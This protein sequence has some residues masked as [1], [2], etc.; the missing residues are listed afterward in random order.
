MNKNNVEVYDLRAVWKT[1]AY[2]AFW[3]GVAFFAIYPTCN[4]ISSQRSDIYKLYFEVELAIPFI[5]EFL[6]FYMSMYLLF[7]LP[8]FFLNVSELV[9]LGKRIILGTII[10]GVIFLLFPATLG[11]ERIVPNGIYGE[12]FSNIFTLDLPYNMAPSLHIVY[13]ALILWGIYFSSSNKMVHLIAL[14]WILLISLSTLLV[15]QHHIMDIVLAIMVILSVI[16][17]IKEGE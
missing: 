15:H 6:W 10:S 8:P 1:Y 3:V 9:V 16:F 17:I 14:L 7:F 4:W 5:P 12:L 13:S 11:F 2:W